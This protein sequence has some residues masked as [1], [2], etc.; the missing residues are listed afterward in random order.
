M[1]PGCPACRDF[2]AASGLAL[3]DISR[4]VTYY[5][6]DGDLSA[7]EQFLALP[8]SARD[9]SGVNLAA[10]RDACHFQTDYPEIVKR[11]ERYFS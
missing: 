5:E 6:Q 10:L 1:C 3:L 2:A 7:R 11:A 9:T 4:F 8:A